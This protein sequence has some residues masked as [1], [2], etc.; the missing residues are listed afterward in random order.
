[1]KAI[2]MDQKI[3]PS[4]EQLHFLMLEVAKEAKIKAD[5]VQK[6]IY[7]KIEFLITSKKK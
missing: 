2:L 5:L 4:D 1:M 7:E 3:D 6:K